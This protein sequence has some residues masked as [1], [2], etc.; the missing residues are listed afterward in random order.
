MTMLTIISGKHIANL[1]SKI[2]FDEKFK[3]VCDPEANTHV[4]IARESIILFIREFFEPEIKSV[5]LVRKTFA[6]SGITE[7]TVHGIE[8]NSGEVLLFKYLPLNLIKCI[9]IPLAISNRINGTLQIDMFENNLH[10][11][12]TEQLFRF[13]VKV[14]KQSNCDIIITTNSYELLE[15]VIEQEDLDY[16]Y[17]RMEKIGGEVI[18]TNFTKEELKCAIE[19]NW[20]VR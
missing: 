18:S 20:E 6:N 10:Y 11:T 8:L 7:L 19:N 9:T 17:T 14:A 16:E 3:L 12:T 15:M 13:A 2:T 4:L 1:K 5:I